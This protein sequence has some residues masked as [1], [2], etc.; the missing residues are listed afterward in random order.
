MKA[1]DRMRLAPTDDGRP[2]VTIE[3]SLSGL[4]LTLFYDNENL[5]KGHQALRGC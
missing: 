2:V 5:R 1:I 3:E 4:L